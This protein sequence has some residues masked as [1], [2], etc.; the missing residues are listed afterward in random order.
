MCVKL[1]LAI[2]ACCV[3]CLVRAALDTHSERWQHF[4]SDN[5]SNQQDQQIPFSDLFIDLF[6]ISSACFGASLS[7]ETCR[8]NLKRSINGICCILLVAY[9]VNLTMLHLTSVSFQSVFVSLSV[10][11]I[12]LAWVQNGPLGFGQKNTAYCKYKIIGE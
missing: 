10:G 12:E 7:P 11:Q 3:N 5:V 8:A 9:V 2:A 6:K 1:L 4:H